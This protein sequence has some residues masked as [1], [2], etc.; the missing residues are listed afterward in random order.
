M[1]AIL[2]ILYRI[3]DHQKYNTIF[4]FTSKEEKISL[5]G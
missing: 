5:I 1:I 4:M 2:I 3:M